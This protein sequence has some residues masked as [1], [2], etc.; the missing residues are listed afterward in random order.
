MRS[1]I[2]VLATLAATASAFTTSTS[3]R[4]TGSARARATKTRASPSMDMAEVIANVPQA[5]AAANDGYEY[6]AVNAPG[7]VLPV[8]A[9]AVILT[10]AVPVLLSPGEEALEQQRIDEETLRNEGRTSRRK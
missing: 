2:L 1:L 4:W 10:A 5:I 9:L 7:W 6:G 8:G 3:T